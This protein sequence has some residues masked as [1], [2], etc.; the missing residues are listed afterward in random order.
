MKLPY[1]KNAIIAKEKLTKYVL[2]E[3]HAVGKFKANFFRKF[4]F[5][6]T[7]VPLLEKALRTIEQSEE[8]KEES[9]SV[10]GTKYVINGRIKT[11]IGNA[12]KVQTVWI[13]EEKQKHPRFITVYP[14]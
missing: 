11:P 8:V 2:S 5:D 6:E 14:V 9:K 13:I 4:G 10:Y 3:T 12:I 7:N 1:N